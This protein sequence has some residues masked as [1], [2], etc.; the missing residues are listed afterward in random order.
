MYF[1]ASQVEMLEEIVSQKGNK[2]HAVCTYTH[3]RIFDDLLAGEELAVFGV[4]VRQLLGDA[5]QRIVFR[6]Q[7]SSTSGPTFCNVHCFVACT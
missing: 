5:Q 1:R 6:A 4:V 2:N 3:E 7:V